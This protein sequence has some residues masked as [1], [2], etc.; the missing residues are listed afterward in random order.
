MSIPRADEHSRRA[1]ST[2]PGEARFIAEIQPRTSVETRSSMTSVRTAAGSARSRASIASASAVP[3]PGDVAITSIIA[4]APS[5]SVSGWT[6][7]RRAS[8]S[9]SDSS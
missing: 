7:P 3:L 6:R 4:T 2:P 8:R 5:A 9:M 1:P